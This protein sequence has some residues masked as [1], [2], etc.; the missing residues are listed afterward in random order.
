VDEDTRM[1][2][3]QWS[4][5]LQAQKEQAKMEEDRRIVQLL[6]EKR[7]LEEQIQRKRDEKRRQ[8]EEEQRKREQEQKKK[9]EEERKR[10][11]EKKR[12]E[13]EERKRIEEEERKRIL[14]AENR[15]RNVKHKISNAT[16]KKFDKR[17]GKFKEPTKSKIKKFSKKQCKKI[18]KILGIEKDTQFESFFDLKL[19]L[20]RVNKAN[21]YI[22]ANIDR[23]KV[24]TKRPYPF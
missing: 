21:D 1:R 24:G 5:T 13:E 10:E 7:M 20:E 22:N 6:R 23:K 11:Q 17:F 9:E 2:I 14:E 3:D 15:K 4:K 18:L 8:R 16:L 19:D 12:I